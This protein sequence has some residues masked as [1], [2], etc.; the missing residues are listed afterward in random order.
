MS[1]EKCS[2]CR[3]E[4]TPSDTK[5]TFRKKVYHVQCFRV[6]KKTGL[7]DIELRMNYV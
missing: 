3:K 6:A 5:K 2:W 4:I 1:F 7:K